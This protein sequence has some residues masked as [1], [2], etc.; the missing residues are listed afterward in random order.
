MSCRRLLCF[1]PSFAPV[2]DAPIGFGLHELQSH[3]RSGSDKPTGNTAFVCTGLMTETYAVR[4]LFSL[5]APPGLE[6]G[7]SALKGPR[8]NQLHHGAKRSVKAV[9]DRQGSI[10]AG[11]TWVW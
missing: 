10:A 2:A 6:P 3:N 8:V 4:K 9:W 5:V 11:T 1:P 7:L